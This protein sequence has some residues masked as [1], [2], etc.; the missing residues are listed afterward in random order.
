[1]RWYFYLGIVLVAFAEFNFS[2]MIQPFALWYLPIVWYGYILLVDG[3]VHRFRGKSLISTYPREFALMVVLSVPFWLI[4]EA[5]N[6]YDFS[7][8]YFHFSIM[9]HLVNF[10]TIMPALL[11]T[12]SL[13]S[14]LE[15]GKGLDFR[16]RA[17]GRK[18]SAG[19]SFP[20]NGI[21][22]LVI[23]GLLVSLLPFFLPSIGFLFMWIGLFLLIDPLNYLT[24]RPSIVNKLSSGQRSI[25]ARLF[26]S[27]LTMGLFW[28]FWNYQAY[29]KWTYAISIFLSNVKLFEMP[30]FGYIGY[31]PFAMEAFLFYALFRSFFFKRGN[32]LLSM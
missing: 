27:G 22:L 21:W 13:F 5:Y 7:W 11:E 9:M 20:V 17:S 28:E 24:G 2:A 14:V 31:L 8:Q 32:E 19:G 3:L 26:L 10:T 4:F 15:V 16:K 18:G 30:I 23:A 29:P 1:M 6:L 12:F 25:V